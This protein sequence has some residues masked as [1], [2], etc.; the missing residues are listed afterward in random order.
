MILILLTN[1][2]VPQVAGFECLYLKVGAQDRLGILLV[3]YPPCYATIS[4]PEL[5]EL[6]SEVTL[7]SSRLVV[8][9]N[10]IVQANLLGIAQDKVHDDNRSAP[11][12][13]WHTHTCCRAHSGVLCTDLT[14]EDLSIEGGELSG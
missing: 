3:Y 7:G 13:T 5:E 1:C 11:C 4:Q 14:L 10:L 12:V 9:G 2:P 8:L 6:I